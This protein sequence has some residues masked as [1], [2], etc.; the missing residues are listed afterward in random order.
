[1]KLV[2]AILTDSFLT[3]QQQIDLVRYS[4]TIE[5]VQIDVIDG[6]FADNITVTPLDLTVAEFDPIKIDFH[7]MAEEPMDFV[8]ECEGVKEYLPIRRIYGQI[9]RMSYQSE[10]LTAIRAN[11]WQAGLALDLFTPIE[12]VEEDV[13]QDLRY[14]LLMAVEAGQQN[15]VFHNQVF[16]KITELR[17]RFSPEQLHI[18]VDGGIKLNNAAK[19]IEA[20]ANEINVGSA[21]WS[22]ADPAQTIEEFFR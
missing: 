16:E 7:L 18:S 2:P 6:Q 4:P 20:G 15:Q 21:L 10:F 19:V 17:E 13:W 22:T 5:A 14:V 1:M 9:E 11:G 3:A 8:Y 12:E